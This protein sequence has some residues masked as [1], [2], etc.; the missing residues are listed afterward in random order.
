VNIVYAV[1]VMPSLIQKAGCSSQPTATRGN[2]ACT[3]FYFKK[4]YGLR[5]SSKQMKLFNAWDRMDPVN[6][7]ECQIH[8]KKSKVQ[9]VENPFVAKHC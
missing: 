6:A 5:I 8:K 1:N 4:Q 7:A 3:Y 9:K 2:I